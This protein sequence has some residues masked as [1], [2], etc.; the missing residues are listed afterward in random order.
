MSPMKVIRRSYRLGDLS[1]FVF[2]FLRLLVRPRKTLNYLLTRISTLLQLERSLGLPLHV[3]LEPS[4]D[5]NYRCIKCGRHS[6]R[7]ADDALPGER[8][9]LPFGLFA[10]VMDELGPALISVRLWHYGES[11]LHEDL[12]RMIAYARRKGVIVA[13][14]SN[15]ALLDEAL[16]EA[17]VR[18]GLDYLIVSF[19]GASR[20]TYLRYHGVDRFEQVLRNLDILVRK[21]AELRSATPFVDLQFIVMRENE[22]EVDEIRRLAADLGVDKLTLLKVDPSQ[23]DYHRFEGVRD[24]EDLLPR[25]QAYRFDR[26]AVSRLRACRIPWEEAVIRYS[27]RVLPCVT[28]IEAGAPMGRLLPDG[29]DQGFRAIWNNQRYR[30]LRRRI[31]AD[32]D[33]VELC[34][35]CAQRD[36]NNQDQVY[37]P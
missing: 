8:R 21:K 15:L 6:P 16:A 11:L 37:T 26:E 31:R 19:D 9:L 7:F 18:G 1:V 24:E 34:R 28:D 36:N 3:H 10:R 20:E 2:P 5:C 29:R 17:L 30:D 12:P 35:G 32:I 25:G 27:G 13:L 22:H 14:S 33:A 4:G 23:V